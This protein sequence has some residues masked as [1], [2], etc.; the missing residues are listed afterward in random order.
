MLENDISEIESILK[1]AGDAV[2]AYYRA[3]N[4]TDYHIEL[5]PDNSPITLADIASN[6]ILLSFLSKKYPHIPVISEESS[7]ADYEFRK[8]YDYVWLLDPLDGTKEFINK[9]DEF[10]I[11]LALIQKGIPV[12]GFIYLPVNQALYFG[13]KNKGSFERKNGSTLKL[14]AQLYTKNEKGI[15]VVASRSPMDVLTKRLI[16]ELQEP[17]LIYLGSA[18]KFVSIAKGEAVYYPRMIQ[19]MEWDTAA[20]QIIIEEAGG[21]LVH[22]ETGMPLTYNKKSML[23]PYFIA[24]GKLK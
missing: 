21:S 4:S 11:N 17:E 5:K 3:D 9:S 15:K 22:A 13:L 18:L 7:I 1:I 19:I 8:N 24:Y 23:N 2:M 14:N 6:N 12:A 20:G 10:S 16:E